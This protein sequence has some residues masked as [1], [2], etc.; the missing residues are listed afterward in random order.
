MD[1]DILDRSRPYRVKAPDG[2]VRLLVKD[3]KEGLPASFALMGTLAKHKVALRLGGGCKGMSAQDKT[4]MIEFFRE[5]F[6][7]Y[8]GLIWSGATRQVK[9]GQ[10]DP[11]VTDV[12]GIIAQDNPGCIALGTL[13]RT[14]MLSLREDSRFVLD[15]YGTVVN[16][17]TYGVLIVQN[18]A[19]GAS[20]WDGDV[21]DYFALMQSWRDHAGFSALGV[22]AWNG[23]D[24]TKQE[25]I[26]SANL[27]WP[28]Y[29]VRGSGRACDEIIG[30]I[31]SGK[32][33][34][35]SGLKDIKT[36]VIVSKYSPADLRNQL[37]MSGFFPQVLAS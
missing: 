27:G 21:N 16:P 20:G 36:L 10:V 4:Q 9:D 25:I 26:R 5:A 23:G 37:M 32:A 3:A 34:T 18:G 12:P 29:L 1:T 15:D 11:M 8:Q 7:G 24:I 31:E 35:I 33:D 6:R 13:P 2:K 19:D 30:A 28:T 17:D 22:C 14:S